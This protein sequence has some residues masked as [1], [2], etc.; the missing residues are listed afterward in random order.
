MGTTLYSPPHNLDALLIGTGEFSFALGATSVAQAN[1]LGYRD[2][3][4]VKAFQ[5]DASGE[6]KEHF[7][8]YRGILARDD[9]RKQK[10]KVGYKLTNDE[11][12]YNTLK[13]LFFAT[14]IG[15]YLRA[16]LAAV[17]GTPIPGTAGL[18]FDVM[19]ANG[20]RVR[21]LTAVTFPNKT[22]G[23]DFEVDYT[24]GRVRFLTPQNAALTPTITAA[25]VAAGSPGSLITSAPLTQNIFKG[26]GRLVCFD[27][28]PVQPVMWEHTDFGCQVEIS[29]TPDV[30][31]DD[32]S[33][34]SLS[35]IV[36][37]PAG[38]L[39]NRAA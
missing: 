10:I 28:N 7:G 29:G 22:E 21:Q 9:N 8:S 6:D 24:L 15:N 11:W 2:F 20:N 19:D 17:A 39:F 14:P 18:F 30:K 27:E 34:M 16:A 3:G 26:F 33:D 31:G 35:V 5:V 36:T 23:T 32:Y 4:N 37:S 12:S 13:H 38:V 1:Q 25:A